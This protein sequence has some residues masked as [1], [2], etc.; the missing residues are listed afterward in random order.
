MFHKYP[1]SSICPP[2]NLPMSGGLPTPPIYY[3][4]APLQLKMCE[5]DVTNI[6]FY[7]IEMSTSSMASQKCLTSLECQKCY[8]I[9]AMSTSNCSMC[10]PIL[11]NLESTWNPI[12]EPQNMHKYNKLS[13]EL[14]VSCWAVMFRAKLRV[15]LWRK[16]I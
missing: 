10:H 5:Y 13:V 14:I 9:R 4:L 1:P 7:A 16:I 15:N 12:K 6:I 3:L 2:P 8:V 11:V